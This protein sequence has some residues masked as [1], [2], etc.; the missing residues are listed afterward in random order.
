M[1]IYITYVYACV[2]VGNPF[3]TKVVVH[4]HTFTY[5]NNVSVYACMYST[6]VCTVEPV[7]LLL[8]CF[9]SQYRTYLL[10]CILSFTKR[11]QRV[12]T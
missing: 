2:G 5:V 12:T 10:A 1:L 3:T 9:L 8:F 7:F 4:L 6:E 11:K